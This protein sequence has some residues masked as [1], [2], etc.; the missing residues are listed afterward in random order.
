M[1][2]MDFKTL[3]KVFYDYRKQTRNGGCEGKLSA[4]FNVHLIH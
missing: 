2:V 1:V 3:K 4:P